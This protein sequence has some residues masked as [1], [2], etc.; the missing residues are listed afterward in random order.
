MKS[1]IIIPVYNVEKTLEQCVRSILTQSFRDYQ[2]ILIDDGSTDNSYEIC[3]KLA[4]EDHRIQIVRQENRGLSSA[5]NKGLSKSHG[6]YVTFVDSDDTMKADT[7]AP[8]MQQLAIHH[9]YDILEYPIYVHYGDPTRQYKLF[10]ADHVYTDMEEYWLKGKAYQHTYACNKIYRRE[11]F[12]DVKFPEG[13]LFEDV[14]TLPLLLKK[15]QIVA[16]TNE[17][18]YYY[19]ANPKGIT[20]TADGHALLDL[21]EAHLPVL[22]DTAN[23]T[24][25]AKAWET[26]YA[27]VLN[28]QLDVY[29]KKG[30]P[31]LLPVMDAHGTLKLKLLHI[32]GL[33]RLCQLN[34]CLHKIYRR[35]H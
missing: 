24:Q 25:L 7:L 27:H 23:N 31:L 8:L 18:M 10:P 3:K 6:E 28:I 32:I 29:E 5:R 1:S 20:A 2:L 16:T 33:K 34:R 12:S 4:Q 22:A 13:R 19:H 15:C 21:L 11:L 9:D 26:Y 17:G 30:G 14:Y 35:S